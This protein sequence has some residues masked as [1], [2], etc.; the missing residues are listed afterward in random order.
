M[1]RG[2]IV[3]RTTKSG[4]KR[5]YAALW[6]EKPD[7]TRKQ[8][9]RTFDLKRNAEAFLDAESKAVR[10]GDNIEPSKITFGQF[11]DEWLKKYPRLAKT[12]W[13]DSTFK[14]YASVVAGHLLPFFG[15]KRLSQIKSATIERDF[16]AQLS[17]ELSPKTVRNIL[18]ILR[19]MLETAVQWDYLRTNP[20]Y[21][22]KRINLPQLSREQQ[23]R[24]LTPEEISKLLECCDGHAY[25][26]VAMGVYTAMRRGELFGHSWEDCDFE[27]NQIHVRQQLYWRRGECWGD[28]RHGYIFTSP[29]S[30]NSIRA[31][32][33]GARLKK[34]LLEH[35]LRS[36]KPEQGLVFAN[37]RDTP[38]TLTTSSNATFSRL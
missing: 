27:R 5:Y 29:K 32:D 31:I 36:G 38:S 9:W 2:T 4:E 10:E 20:F 21:L 26:V 3:T 8:V 34:I 35:Q 12:P 37:F 17:A 11:A 7:G 6:T 30:K 14:S 28:Q 24:A 33:M 25:P 16:K 18:L 15:S 13:K 19:V 23:G 22:H 1:A